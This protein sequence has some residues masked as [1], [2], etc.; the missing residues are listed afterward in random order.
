MSVIFYFIS[1]SFLFSF[2][3]TS[4]YF[5]CN[6]FSS[7][8]FLD[9]P[10]VILDIEKKELGI[11][12]GLQDRVIQTYKGLVLM[13]FSNVSF[14]FAF[15]IFSLYFSLFLLLILLEFFLLKTSHFLFSSH[16]FFLCIA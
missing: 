1:I 9:F 6:I 13:D 15:T 5:I 10:Q 8:L 3:H 16:L 7:I 2:P 11:S 4:F 14:P 12:A